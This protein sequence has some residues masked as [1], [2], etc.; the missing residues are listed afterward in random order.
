M[1]KTYCD[2]CHK[3]IGGEKITA[4]I[5]A[6]YHLLGDQG[7]KEYHFH[8]ECAARLKNKFNHVTD[9]KAFWEDTN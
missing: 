9:D 2:F 7:D 3:E 8:R 4:T 1:Y 6:D 5:T